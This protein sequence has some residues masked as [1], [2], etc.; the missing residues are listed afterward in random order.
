MVMEF[1]YSLHSW[2]SDSISQ[3]TWPMMLGLIVRWRISVGIY[4]RGRDPTLTITSVP[5][6]VTTQSMSVGRLEQSVM[7]LAQLLLE[8]HL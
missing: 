2:A 6:Y 5:D 4:Q 8:T 1:V 7:T 3:S